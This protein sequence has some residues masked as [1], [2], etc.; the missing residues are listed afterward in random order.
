MPVNVIP[1]LFLIFFKDFDF[2]CLFLFIV[3]FWIVDFGF[4]FGFVF[5]FGYASV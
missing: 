1:V 5:R 2:C 4:L 3:L